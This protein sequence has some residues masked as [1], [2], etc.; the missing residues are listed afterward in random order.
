MELDLGKVKQTDTELYEKII[1]TNG[2]VRFGKDADGKS[3][4]VVTDTETNSDTVIAFNNGLP[5]QTVFPD[6][7]YKVRQF[8]YTPKTMFGLNLGNNVGF[9]VN[10]F[11]GNITL[12]HFTLPI[13]TADGFTHSF[14]EYKVYAYSSFTG[15]EQYHKSQMVCAIAA[16]N[17]AYRDESQFTIPIIDNDLCGILDIKMDSTLMNIANIQTP[18]TLTTIQGSG[19]VRFV[20][21]QGK[22]SYEREVRG[23]LHI[24]FVPPALS[25][26]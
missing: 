16:H 13:I 17:D 24:G 15:M 6:E 10:L 26:N 19:T 7:M 11:G 14:S 5:I 12:S 8:E 25:F 4:Y 2:G 23:V 22:T 9:N 18:N 3:G 1:E 21:L 20:T